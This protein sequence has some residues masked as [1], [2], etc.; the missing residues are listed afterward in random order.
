MLRNTVLIFCLVFIICTGRWLAQTAHANDPYFAS[1]GTGSTG[2][3]YY[4][5]AREIC[6]AVNRRYSGV[7]RCSPEATAGSIY[8]LRALM[9]KELEFALVQSDWHYHAYNGSDIFENFG[10]MDNLRSVMALYVEPFTMVVQ[11]DSNIKSFI[12]LKGKR[13]DIG[14]PSSGRRATMDVVMRTYDIK[15]SEFGSVH[16]L[17]TGD[18]VAALCKNQIDA[19]TL[20]LGHPSELIARALKECGAVL[21]PVTGPEVDQLIDKHRYY[22]HAQ[23]LSS[24]YENLEQNINT[25]GV[26]ATV[27]TVKSIPSNVVAQF[28]STTLEVLPSLV[29]S[30]GVLRSFD[31]ETMAEQGLTAPLHR[32][33]PSASKGLSITRK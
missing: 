27:V 10:P 2:G 16:E 31:M 11:K 18:I 24:D 22:R 15:P 3:N 26:T 28:V 17:N 25:F 30:I 20:I 1:F 6:R 8:N 19:T 5:T 29:E 14:H 9:E 23:I 32:G 4:K 21:V 12:D 13:V 33:A 7:L